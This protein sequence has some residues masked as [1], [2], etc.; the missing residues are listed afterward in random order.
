MKKVLLGTMAVLTL[1]ACSKDEV[2]QHNPNDEITFTAVTN[3]AVSRAADGFCNSSMPGDFQVWAEVD[4]KNYFAQERYLRSGSTSTY[5]ID[6]A[7][8]YWPES[9]T[10]KINFYAACNKGVKE[11]T[12]EGGGTSIVAAESDVAINGWTSETTATPATKVIEGYTIENDV[13]KQKDLLYAVVKGATRGTASSGQIAIN[14]RHALSQIEFMAQNKN[15]NIYVEISQ[16]KVCNVNGKGDFTFPSTT[17][18]NI[19]DKHDFSGTYPD[20]TTVGKWSNW[21]SPA[22]YETTALIGKK[23]SEREYDGDA[24][25]TPSTAAAA[26]SL[27]TADDEGKEYSSNTMYLLPQTI[28]PWNPA[29]AGKPDNGT[30]AYFLVK[31]KIWNVAAGDG[32][33]AATGDVVLWDNKKGANEQFIAIPIPS[34]TWEPGKRYVYTFIFTPD[35][36]G[37][38]NPEPTDPGTPEPVLVPIKLSVTVDDFVDGGTVPGIEMKKP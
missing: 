29:T 37:G 32:T 19:K 16:V 10:Q 35:G 8:R 36:N 3:K 9:T 23:L 22:S 20:A 38:Y 6:G 4:G 21:S 26:S 2:I 11:I 17:D 34:I 14:F 7:M 25:K 31:A 18:G 5:T 30:G 15:K 33:R 13:A 12:E 1:A 27:T 28:T 24:L